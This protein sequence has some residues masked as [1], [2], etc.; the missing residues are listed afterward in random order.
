MRSHPE[1]RVDERRRA[2]QHADERVLPILLVMEGGMDARHERQSREDEQ[3][4]LPILP[5]DLRWR[6]EEEQEQG[7]AED[8][9]VKRYPRERLTTMLHAR[10]L[11]R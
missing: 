2:E 11:I 8:A 4:E 6:E 10:T 7:E 5:G 1:Q 9:R 3:D